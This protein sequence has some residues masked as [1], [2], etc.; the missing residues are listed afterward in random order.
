M[1]EVDISS[2]AE[3]PIRI[4]E[5]IQPFG[6]LLVFDADRRLVRFSHDAH[7]VVCCAEP[8]LRGI[9]LSE[10]FNEEQAAFLEAVFLRLRASG[11]VRA[12]HT[13]I[14]ISQRELGVCA[15][16]VECF[17]VLELIPS[18]SDETS[19]QRFA[20]TREALQRLQEIPGLQEKLDYSVQLLKLL[21][22]FDRVIV[23]QFDIDYDGVVL[24]EA[25][26]R[27]QRSFLGLHYPAS[28]IPEQARALYLENLIRFIPDVNYTP[29]SLTNW[30]GNCLDMS[31]SVLRAISPMHIQ[32]MKNM[33]VQSTLVGSLINNG[34]L[35][36]LIACHHS[37]PMSY[38][39]AKLELFRWLVIHIGSEIAACCLRDLE[40]KRSKALALAHQLLSKVRGEDRQLSD[41]FEGFSQDEL[42][43]VT[44][45][46]GVACFL[47]GEYSS[48]GKLPA[49]PEVKRIVRKL[50]NR[51]GDSG[52]SL[53]S[54]HEL[55]R[56]LNEPASA[57]P[58]SA[59]LAL[60][61]IREKEGAYMIFF[62][63]EVTRSVTWAGIPDKPVLKTASGLTPRTSFQAW[64]QK[65]SGS[66]RKW[67]LEE[68][69]AIQAFCGIVDIELKK[70]AERELML[71]SRCID[72]INDIVIVTD[73][74]IGEP[75]PR[76]VFVNKA[77]EKQT[78][79]SKA[80]VLGRSPR[81]LQS[82]K[83]NKTTLSLIRERLSEGMPVRVELQNITKGGVDYWTE[84]DISPVFNKTGALTNCI[85]VQRDI[86]LAKSTN[87]TLRFIA[88]R[89]WDPNQAN[90]LADLSAHILESLGLPAMLVATCSKHGQF[91]LSVST[92]LFNGIEQPQFNFAVP[93]GIWNNDSVEPFFSD[94]FVFCHDRTSPQH[95]NYEGLNHIAG[96]WLVDEYGSREA[97]IILLSMEPIAWKKQVNEKLRLIQT[98][99]ALD[100]VRK[101]TSDAM[102]YQANYDSL[103]GIPNRRMFN[104]RLQ[105]ALKKR[106]PVGTVGALLL[107]DLDNFKDINDLYGHAL[108]DRLLIQVVQR[109]SDAIR[110][111]DTIAR[112]GG[113]EFIIILEGLRQFSEVSRVA[114]QILESIQTP[115]QID[116]HVIYSSFSI[117]ATVFPTD[118]EDAEQLISFADQAMYA[119]KK[120]GKNRYAFFTPG[121]QELTAY[122][123]K[124][125]MDLRLA[126][127]QDELVVYFQPV[128]DFA[129]SRVVKAEALLRWQHPE[130]GM[131]SPLDFIPIAEETGQII[132]I[133]NWVF[134]R[135]ANYVQYLREN[136]DENFAI[137]VNKSPV[138]FRED[139]KHQM[140]WL[141]YL[142]SIGL[143]PSAIIVEI[144]ESS[145]M[146]DVE[147][148]GSM[149]KII[150]KEGVELALDDFGTGYS[151]M[152]YLQRFDFD[153]L[154]I[155]QSFVRTMR[156]DSD[157]L[158][159]VEAIIVMAKKLGIKVVAEGVETSEQAELLRLAGADFGQGFFFSGP[160]APNQLER[161]LRQQAHS[162]GQD[163][164][165][166][167]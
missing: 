37:E 147:K 51:R 15:Y 101:K 70:R 140:G 111:S 167:D 142:K 91:P 35:W 134:S 4:P 155:D 119:A 49:E 1:S 47:K 14:R 71:L 154:K 129:T 34:K 24:A 110:E 149:L 152:A 88:E 128:I 120:G 95:V 61:S 8:L 59:G 151:A 92:F 20:Q 139:P 6:V 118:S 86:S 117:G 72:N 79:Y 158:S 157:E 36:G 124:L 66:S 135:A 25:K 21:T 113:D 40:R 163:D 53:Y 62:R 65:V 29:R 82:E 96:V 38:D 103:T 78:G 162:S 31:Q 115:F 45:A 85:S 76:I 136:F 77:F 43:H 130:K 114:E 104:D 16:R 19:Y 81:M 116:N 23:Y 150:Q 93:E 125:A 127:K 166:M 105:Q 109:F 165:F 138:Q 10:L 56:L 41:L 3:E 7:S 80:E 52:S 22:G 98:H 17:D 108:G 12:E 9:S 102:W 13:S 44:G 32:Y 67:Q 94:S 75:G 46:C 68:L 28:D 131:I 30:S 164:G 159:M 39:H 74:L 83:T 143:P 144:T 33:G 57:H 133:G 121:M 87:D 90:F 160:V 84:A 50:L 161:L 5:Q 26:Q 69:E 145:V 100:L 97:I 73:E 137:S 148:V 42:L 107:L 126:I 153:Y 54:T 48:C 156:C 2:C 55:P 27:E 132:P 58:Y 64:K 106:W 122:R 18:V 60:M 63:E 146:D 141:D 89:N 99:V 123:S 11:N 112:L